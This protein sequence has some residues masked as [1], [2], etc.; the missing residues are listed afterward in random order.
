MQLSENLTLRECTKSTTTS[1]LGINNTP[2]EWETENLRQIARYVFQPLRDGLG[3]PIYVSSG[4]R[5]LIST[6]RSA[7][8][9]VV[10]IFRGELS[11]W[12]Q[13]FTG[14]LQT[15]RSS[16]TY[17][18]AS[19]LISSF[20]SLVMKTILIGFTLSYVHDGDNRG[21]VLKAVRD[22]KG[23]VVYEVIFD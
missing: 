10:S 23:Q 8:Q 9:V 22:D 3:V 20:G 4:Y 16:S 5:S 18:A 11:T 14:A 19:N 21:R 2:D 7:A 15:V 1:R 13:T 12:T 6:L 17:V